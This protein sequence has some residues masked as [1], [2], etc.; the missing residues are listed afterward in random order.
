MFRVV[1]SGLL[2]FFIHPAEWPEVH[3]RAHLMGRSSE[4][5]NAALENASRFGGHRRPLKKSDLRKSVLSAGLFVAKA[6]RYTFGRE[7]RFCRGARLCPT[8]REGSV[9]PPEPVFFDA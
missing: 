4:V 6:R 9:L 1:L 8:S 3:F 7:R 5:N 2:Y